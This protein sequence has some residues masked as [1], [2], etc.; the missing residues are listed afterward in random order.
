MSSRWKDK[1]EL[2]DLSG[3]E[4]IAATSIAGGPKVGGGTIP[5]N[6][7]IHITPDQL[8]AW[9]LGKLRSVQSVTSAGTV[10]P[11]VSD[12]EVWVTLQAGALTIADPTGTAAAGQNFLLKIKDDGTARALIW[13]AG[14]RGMGAVLAGSTIAGKWMTFPISRNSTDSKWDVY[15]PTVQQ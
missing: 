9:V 7:D 12:S 2:I 6:G 10:T 15:P 14:Y 11:L 13:G 5:A 3:T 4:A 8:Y 1:P